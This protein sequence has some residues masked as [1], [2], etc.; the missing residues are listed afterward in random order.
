MIAAFNPDSSRFLHDEFG[1]LQPPNPD[2]G[3]FLHDESGW[4]QIFA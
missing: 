3:S 1:W 2:S 4:L